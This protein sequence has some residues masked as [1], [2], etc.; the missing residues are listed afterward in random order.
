MSGDIRF[1]SSLDVRLNFSG[2]FMQQSENEEF[3]SDNYREY[4]KFLTNVWLGIFMALIPLS[5]ICFLCSSS[6]MCYRFK[7]WRRRS[8]SDNWKPVRRLFGGRKMLTLDEDFELKLPPKLS[9][10]L[11]SVEFNLTKIFIEPS[12][13][14]GPKL[15]VSDQEYEQ[16]LADVWVGIVL[17]L[18]VLSCVCFM[19]SCLIYHKFQQWKTRVIQAR[20]GG[21]LES[22]VAESELPS[23]TIA[24]GLPTYEEALQQLQ[25][26]DPPFPAKP[27]ETS[28]WIPHTP[29]T[30]A[31]VSI[32]VVK[33]FQGCGASDSSDLA[34]DT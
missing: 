14:D 28:E 9:E 32:N 18:M 29:P 22:G 33:F 13:F 27:L 16:F 4:H 12:E 20:N 17:T 8:T 6:V 21:N 25:V 5:C 1:E 19:C 15:N 11:N 26:K 34:K 30:P 23:Y 31:A 7:Q 10:E 3:L 24:S 2:I